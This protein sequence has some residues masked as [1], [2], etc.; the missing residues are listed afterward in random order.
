MGNLTFV[1]ISGSLR[2]ASRNTGLLRCCAAHLP[3]GVSLEIADISALPFYNADIEKPA[4]VQRLIDQVSAAD[5]LVLACPEYNYSLAPALKNALDCKRE[6][7]AAALEDGYE[8]P[9]PTSDDEYSGQFKLR[10]PKSLH[11]ALAENSKREGISMNQYCL[12]LLT[13]NN[14]EF[15]HGA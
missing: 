12:Y 8:I 11:R 7:L 4:V 9:E 2:K 10:L 3:Q 13:K 14:A 6:W 1:G 5:G 15:R